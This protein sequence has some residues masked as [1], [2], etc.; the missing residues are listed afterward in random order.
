[1]DTCKTLYVF[2]HS[3]AYSEDDEDDE[4]EPTPNRHKLYV[5]NL[6]LKRHLIL[7]LHMPLTSLKPHPLLL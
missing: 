1:M 6:A 5:V 7:S 2:N 3:A 4:V